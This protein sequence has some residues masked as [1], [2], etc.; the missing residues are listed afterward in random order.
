MILNPF[1]LIHALQLWKYGKTGK[2]LTVCE[3]T[4]IELQGKNRDEP[5]RRQNVS[6]DC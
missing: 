4:E 3:Q 1:S 2:C 6:R 5:L